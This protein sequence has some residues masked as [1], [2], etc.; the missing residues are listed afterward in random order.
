MATTQNAPANPWFVTRILWGSLLI[1]TFLYLVVLHQ[2]APTPAQPPDP[3]MLPVFGMVALSIAAI[4]LWLPR[5][6][7]ATGVKAALKSDKFASHMAADPD[8]SMI[9]RDETPKL[10]MLVNDKKNRDLVATFFF[11]PFIIGMALS[12]SIAIFG[13]VLG[14]IGF[15]WPEVLSF[16]AVAWVLMIIRFPRPEAVFAQ[17]EK[18]GGVRFEQA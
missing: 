5:M 1:S 15:G 10:R 9:L 13:L 8:A 6:M 18:I 17:F 11:T 16:F 12:E 4:S 14:F 3:I 7:F 2:A